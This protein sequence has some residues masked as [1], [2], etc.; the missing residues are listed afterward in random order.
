MCVRRAFSRIEFVQLQL[1]RALSHHAFARFESFQHGDLLSVFIAQLHFAP[2]ELFARQQHVDYLLA[3]VL[4][5]GLTRNHHCRDGLARLDPHVGLHSDAQRASRI[6]DREDD[7]SGPLL[8]VNHLADVQQRSAKFL[9]R[10]RRGRETR[11]AVSGYQAEV[12]LEYRR[13][14]PE[15]VEVDDLQYRLACGDLF[16]EVLVDFRDDAG[17]GRSNNVRGIRAVAGSL[18]RSWSADIVQSLAA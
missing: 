1:Q 9:P 10:P 8:L 5:Y 2:L 14:D 17:D 3:L 13:F 18:H 4:N 6:G 16:T 12:A 15:D 11:L 7:V